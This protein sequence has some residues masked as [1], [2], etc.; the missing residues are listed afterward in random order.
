MQI[1][2]HASSWR[3]LSVTLQGRLRDAGVLLSALSTYRRSKKRAPTIRSITEVVQ[4]GARLTI[5]W[6]E[7]PIAGE[8]FLMHQVAAELRVAAELSASELLARIHIS[9]QPHSRFMSQDA[10]SFRRAKC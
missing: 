3:F 1:R 5:A 8:T 7:T 9:E 4:D 10:T 2:R 6:L